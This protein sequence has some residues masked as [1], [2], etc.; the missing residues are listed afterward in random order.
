M[1]G[2]NERQR[3][4]QSLLLPL[5][6]IGTVVAVAAGAFLWRHWSSVGTAPVPVPTEEPQGAQPVRSDEPLPLTLFVPADGLLVPVGF[7][8]VSQPE[9]QI[10]AREA[11]AA[12]LSDARG[13]RAAVLNGIRIREFYLDRSGTAYLDL[14]TTDPGG[15]RGSAWD[16]LLAVYSLV[17]TL[18]RNFTEVRQVRFL[19]DGREAQTLAGHIDLTRSFVQRTDLVRSP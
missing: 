16:E 18:T 15:V 11:V 13:S 1:S 6:V 19:L 14:S 2:E 9:V 10:E 3:G 5:I 7:S 8:A 17:N 4:R 12:V